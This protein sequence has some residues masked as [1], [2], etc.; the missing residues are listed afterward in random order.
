MF[1]Y[2]CNIQNHANV[3]AIETKSMYLKETQ[4][5][6]MSGLKCIFSDV[7]CNMHKLGLFSDQESR[8][9][10]VKLIKTLAEFIQ[11]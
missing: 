10:K 1:Y 8:N 11:T 3:H 7:F 2:I 9:I 4:T 6:C 5:K